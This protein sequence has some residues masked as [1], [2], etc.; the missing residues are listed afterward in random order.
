[1]KGPRLS[2][3][4]SLLIQRLLACG[5]AAVAVCCGVLQSA[6]AQA[7]EP[8]S[9]VG[10]SISV[11]RDL[12]AATFQE[13]WDTTPAIDIAATM[14][15]YIGEIRASVR[16][17]HAHAAELTDINS[18]FVNVGW[19]GS[20]PIAGRVRA[21]ASLSAGS[22]YMSFVDEPVSFRKSES[23]LAVGLRTGMTAAVGPNMK[24]LIWT[25]WQHAFTSTPV[26]FVFAGV[27]FQYDFAAP[28][29]LR[30]FLN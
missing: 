23:E 29:W 11:S 3:S 1:M 20:L 25:E 16:V 19:G 5:V 18:A 15:F 2:Y 24:M 14:P 28:D 6:A 12:A 8:F 17:V 7:R 26:D 4:R 21:H 30:R 22:M 10:V 9:T 13:S 27:G